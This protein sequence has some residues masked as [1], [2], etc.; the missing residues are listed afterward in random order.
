M[1]GFMERKKCWQ[2]P[3]MLVLARDEVHLWLVSLEQA[4]ECVSQFW[5]TL[6]PDEQAR[7]ARFVF[8][9]DRRKF[10]VARGVLRALLGHYLQAPAATLRFT[11]N[12]YGKPALEWP[13]SQPA[14]CF[15]L[16]HSHEMALYAFTYERALGVDIEYM[17]ALVLE[18]YLLIARS[19]FSADEYVTLSALPEELRQQA[20]F[21]CWTRKEAYIKTRGKGISI[22][23]DTFTVSLA[24]GEP[25]ALLASR[26]APHTVAAW[27]LSLPTVPPDYAAALMV[28][29]HTWRA[30]SWQWGAA[31]E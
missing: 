31:S 2:P 25:A 20:F 29:G 18:D 15:N 1:M 23:L 30:C 10:T 24:P 14:L 22:P 3:A 28:E 5:A 19:H 13:A 7:A 17:R 27:S 26:E 16:S 6:A 8:E 21:N 9:K 11:Y 12:A 4:P